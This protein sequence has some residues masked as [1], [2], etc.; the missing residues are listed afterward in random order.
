[1][2]VLPAS[3]IPSLSAWALLAIGAALAAIAALKLRT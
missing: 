3:A 2:S 1:V